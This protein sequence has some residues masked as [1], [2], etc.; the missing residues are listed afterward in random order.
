MKKVFQFHPQ[1][2]TIQFLKWVC[3]TKS[4]L[5]SCVCYKLTHSNTRIMYDTYNETS[6]LSFE[7]FYER[8]ADSIS[9]WLSEYAQVWDIE[10]TRKYISVN[11]DQTVILVEKKEGDAEIRCESFFDWLCTC[12]NEKNEGHGYFS[13]DLINALFITTSDQ[14]FWDAQREEIFH[15]HHRSEVQSFKDFIESPLGTDYVE[16]YCESAGVEFVRDEPEYY[17]EDYV[18]AA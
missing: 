12:H 10:L 17:R 2:D 14:T 7:H 9:Q 3:N 15:E 13:F 8:F 18:Q 5:N 4:S 16:K 6:V 11:D 1:V